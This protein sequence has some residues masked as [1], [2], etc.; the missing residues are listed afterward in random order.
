[1]S[2][3][4]QPVCFNMSDA[5]EKELF[6]FAITQQRFFSRYIKRLIERDRDE[7]QT[8]LNATSPKVEYKSD[9]VINTDDADVIAGFF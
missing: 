6:E 8:P 3:R 7:K 9:A 1:M 2:Q 4:N 5:Y